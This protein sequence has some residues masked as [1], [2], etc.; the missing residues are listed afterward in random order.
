MVM[1]PD[2]NEYRRQPRLGQTRTDIRPV[3]LLLGTALQA[4]Y[5]HAKELRRAVG[6]ELFITNFVHF[7]LAL[8]VLPSVT[9]L[10]VPR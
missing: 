6:G 1:A 5:A 2:R 9:T 10:E 3:E 7:E 4:P 8:A